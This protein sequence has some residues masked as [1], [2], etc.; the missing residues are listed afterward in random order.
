MRRGLRDAAGTRHD[1]QQCRQKKDRA[2]GESEHI[3]QPNL[4]L[5]HTLDE[6]PCRGPRATA[7]SAS[8]VARFGE[9]LAERAGRGA[10]RATDQP[11]PVERAPDLQ[12]CEREDREL[13]EAE[14][15]G[16][17]GLRDDR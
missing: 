7:W 9:Q 3:A 15:I 6:A 10:G 8:G 1:Q 14:L 13:V 5:H 12:V 2:G 11:D 4:R 16:D 17:R